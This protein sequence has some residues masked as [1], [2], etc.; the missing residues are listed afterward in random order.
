MGGTAY[1]YD[2]NGNQTNRGSDVLTWD[3]SNRLTTYDPPGAGSTQFIYDADGTRI[4]RLDPDGTATTTIGGVY[5]HVQGGGTP[6]ERVTYRFTGQTV[7]VRTIQGTSN[8]LDWVVTDHLGSTTV[9]RD[10]ATGATVRQWY[11]P[12]GA[13]RANTGGSLPT[14][15]TYTG[16]TNDA[17]TGLMHYNAR[18]YDPDLRRFISADTIIPNPT[19]T[20]DYN[21]YTY[22]HNNPTNNTDP[23]GHCTLS[24]GTVID[25]IDTSPCAPIP[26]VVTGG[27]WTGA[28]NSVI[29]FAGNEH[30][31][32]SPDRAKLD[33][34][35]GVMHSYLREQLGYPVNVMW[36]VSDEM[37]RG[38]GPAPQINWC[39]TPLVDCSSLGADFA[40]AIAH[41]REATSD[42]LSGFVH[43]HASLHLS[44][45]VEQGSNLATALDR[46]VIAAG[47]AIDADGGTALGLGSVDVFV[48]KPVA[49]DPS[50]GWMAPNGPKLQHPTDIPGAVRYDS[51]FARHSDHLNPLHPAFREA[52]RL[53]AGLGLS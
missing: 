5:E 14:E 3:A 37:T 18:Y 32:A 17:S 39:N 38:L 20:R 19:T 22:V 9:T 10:A 51:F 36:V 41:Y 34:R 47:T 26:G 44:I 31:E 27:V 35:A 7:A 25:G 48:S 15:E 1:L 40:T 6:I 24:N 52:M 50:S 8:T 49:K 4:V 16:Q 2:A 46:L 12:Y 42:D 45:A 11:N 23:T 13:Q 28:E 33:E 53:L 21:R 29:Y 43:S 30:T